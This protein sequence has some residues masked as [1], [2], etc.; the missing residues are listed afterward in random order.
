MELCWV[1]WEDIRDEMI[2]L[3]GLQMFC[4]EIWIWTENTKNSINKFW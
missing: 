1:N 3:C 4:D 2:I